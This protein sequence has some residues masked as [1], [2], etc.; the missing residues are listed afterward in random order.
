MS[1]LPVFGDFLGPAGEH[2][3][4]AA[5]FRGE[6]PDGAQRGAVRQIG[7]SSGAAAK[8][9]GPFASRIWP[10]HCRAAPSKHCS[11]CRSAI[12]PCSCAPPSSTK[13]HKTSSPK[14]Q[15]KPT[16]AT[17]SP[18]A[19]H[20]QRPPSRKAPPAQSRLQVKMSQAC[21]RNR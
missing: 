17:A 1:R 10:P 4:A 6:L 18:A 3:T 2:L 15:R 14:Q 21:Q 7:R 5:S 12:R 11:N 20:D 16:A 13:Q 19:P 8:A 9:S